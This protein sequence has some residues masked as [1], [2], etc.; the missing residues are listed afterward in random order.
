MPSF[1]FKDNCLF[2]ALEIK[3]ID[4]KNANRQKQQIRE[5]SSS[6]MQKNIL[7]ICLKRND[8]W[9]SIVHTR[10]SACFDFNVQTPIYH[11]NCYSDFKNM[12]TNYG[13][14]KP[15]NPHLK[16]GFEKLCDFISM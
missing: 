15:Q 8:S 10:V 6:E 11:L 7:D 12:S 16:T 4:P 3:E 9:S 2:C 13:P 14:G 1:N 5:V